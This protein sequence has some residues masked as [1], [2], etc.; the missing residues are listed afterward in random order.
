MRHSE[1]ERRM[2]TI[3]DL[4]VK[5]IGILTGHLHRKGEVCVKF[6]V[7]ATTTTTTTINDSNKI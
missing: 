3:S 2:L 7:L 1:H 4:K 6:M 5:Y